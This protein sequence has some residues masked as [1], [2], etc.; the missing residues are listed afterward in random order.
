MKKLLSDAYVEA[1][2][3]PKGLWIAAVVVPGGLLTIAAYLAGKSAYK[4]FKKKEEKDDRSEN[5]GG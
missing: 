3:L 1:K 5:S 2:S 4:N